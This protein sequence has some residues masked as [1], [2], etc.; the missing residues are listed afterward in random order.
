MRSLT[1]TRLL[2]ATF[3]VTTLL[4][5]LLAVYLVSGHAA[6]HRR[7]TAQRA[8]I[9][10]RLLA[11]ELTPPPPDLQRWSEVAAERSGSR[12]TIF[13][14]GDGVGPLLADSAHKGVDSPTPE[15][16]QARNRGT[17]ATVRQEGGAPS[18]RYYFALALDQP[19]GAVLRLGLPLEEMEQST[20]TLLTGVLLA[21]GLTQAVSLGVVLF[22]WRSLR[23]RIARLRQFVET[24]LDPRSSETAIHDA[25]DEL[26]A[27]SNSLSRMAPQIRDLVHR[28][29]LELSRREAILASMA[30]GVLAVDKKLKVTFY[31][32]AFSRAVGAGGSVPEGQPILRVV[33]DPALVDLLTTVVEDG[34][35]EKRRLQLTAGDRESRS[36]EVQTAPLA[37]PSD[38][39][40]IAIL[41]DIT[42]L[43]RLERIRKDFVANVSHEL[44]TPLAAIRGYAE[45]L[46]EGALEDE[47]NRRKFV[48]IIHAH[49]IRLNNIASDLLTLSELESGRRALQPARVS[50]RGAVEAAVRTVESEARVRGV[51]L[52]CSV[53]DDADVM[54]YKLSLE[55]AMVNLLDNAVKFNR[56]GGEV[57]I[58]A[59]RTPDNCARIVVSDTGIGIPYEDLPRIFERF[60]RVD[61]A[62]SRDVGGTG[63]GLSIVK[64]VIEQMH[65]R[66]SVDSRLGKGSTFTIVF[67]VAAIE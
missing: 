48:E 66:I 16:E 49:A 32:D 2:W 47:A 60:Y 18:G 42:D 50:I 6:E 24:L 63:L 27:L 54:G 4:Q 1:H 38:R 12:V 23:A 9:E 67:P 26:G 46:L 33:R 11:G 37:G 43:E 30:E 21:L 51:H 56:P 53:L 44:R 17:G 5:A 13:G 28:L 10:T 41:H 36:F 39:G 65:G 57:I 25:D 40:A 29:S 31:N 52:T 22:F 34:K 14:P 7:D 64:H 59:N 61:K 45:T 15:V 19:A 62:R 8:S 35:S 58:Q 3:L 55:Q 20:T